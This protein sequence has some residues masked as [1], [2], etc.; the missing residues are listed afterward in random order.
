MR[1][2]HGLLQLV[3]VA[4]HWTEI[5]H[6]REHDRFA[7][8]NAGSPDHDFDLRCVPLGLVAIGFVPYRRRLGP[9]VT[10]PGEI[11]ISVENDGGHTL[12]RSFLDHP[13]QENGLARS[14]PG[15]DGRVARKEIERQIAR[16]F[17][18]SSD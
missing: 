11:V 15:K 12:Q 17:G 1:H 18:L 4:P 6:W 2:G 5:R 10:K 14:A 7:A 8:G 16:L 9:S 13:A 3:L